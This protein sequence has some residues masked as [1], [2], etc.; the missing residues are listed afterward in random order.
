M[1]NLEELYP[2]YRTLNTAQRFTV[3][4]MDSLLQR[5]LNGMHSL[6]FYPFSVK[7]LNLLRRIYPPNFMAIGSVVKKLF[8]HS[9]LFLNIFTH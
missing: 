3:Y 9:L 8:A 2:G 7:F 4:F 6:K 1:N 5:M